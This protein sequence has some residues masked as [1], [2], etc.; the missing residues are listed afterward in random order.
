MDANIVILNVFLFFDKIILLNL[1]ELNLIDME[2]NTD[3][4]KAEELLI[5][6][7]NQRKLMMLK[8]LGLTVIATAIASIVCI[9]MWGG[10]MICMIVCG[11]ISAMAIRS[12]YNEK[13][14]NKYKKEVMPQL[15]ASVC[16]DAR[17]AEDDIDTM[18]I[19]SRKAF[20]GTRLWRSG[21]NDF[22]ASED[23]IMGKIGS[24]KFEFCEVTYGRTK[25]KLDEG[26]AKEEKVPLFTGMAFAADFGRAFV[27]NTVVSAMANPAEM[28][29]SEIE[30][31]EIKL[32][33][34]DYDRMIH[35][36]VTDEESAKNILLETVQEEILTLYKTLKETMNESR[37]VITFSSSRML[38]LIPTFRDRFEV[39]IMRDVHKTTTMEDLKAITQMIHIADVVRHR[40]CMWE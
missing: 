24:V 7:E 26:R 37:L 1:G 38:M 22:L 34:A 40:N 19:C 25:T 18:R 8:W 31:K 35:T 27:G 36:Y 29:E 3:K 12:Y 21:E 4:S 32:N 15:V 5:K 39:E 16:T 11:I 17:Y 6:F 30:Y 14:R 33:S 10:V 20:A 9:N 2:N 23:C 28:K 13:L